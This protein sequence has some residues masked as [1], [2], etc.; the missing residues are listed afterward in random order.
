LFVARSLFEHPFQLNDLMLASCVSWN[1]QLCKFKV[2]VFLVSAL[3]SSV[4][5][6]SNAGLFVCIWYRGAKR[7]TESADFSSKLG[8]L[9]PLRAVVN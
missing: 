7:Y 6:T 8:N 9:K 3:Q 5:E 4:L 2:T 1:C